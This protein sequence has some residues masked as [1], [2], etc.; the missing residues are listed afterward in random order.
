M[1]IAR[2]HYSHDQLLHGH[3]AIITYHHIPSHDLKCIWVLA[4]KHRGLGIQGR[5][6]PESDQLI[7][8]LMTAYR[9]ESAASSLLGVSALIFVIR[10]CHGRLALLPRYLLR[11][12]AVKRRVSPILTPKY[13]KLPKCNTLTLSKLSLIP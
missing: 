5:E 3:N 1:K 9:R 8:I 12:A 11:H 13:D 6:S 10:S 2:P 4:F 7:N